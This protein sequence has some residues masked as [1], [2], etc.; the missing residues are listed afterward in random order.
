MLNEELSD[1]ETKL[2]NYKRGL[3]QVKARLVEFKEN[4][5]MFC[6]RIRVL[7]R[8]VEIS[9]NKIEYLKNELEQVKKEKESLDNKLTGFGNALKDLYNLLG[10]QRSDKNKEGLGY[11]L[12][13]FVDDTV[14][15]YRRPTPI[16]DASKCNKCELQSSNFSV[17]EHGESTCSIMSKPMIKFMKEVDCSRVI[18]INNTE[19]ARKSTVKYAEIAVLLKP[20][21][22]PIVV[23]R[24]NMNVSQPKMTSFAKTA[25][26]NVK[27]SFQRKSTVKNQ[28]RVPRASTV[29]KK[30]PTVDSKFPT[31]KSTLNADLRDKGKAVKAPARWIWRPKQNTSEQEY[32]TD[33][34]QIVDFLEA[35]HIRR[36]LKLNDEE[37]ISSLPDAELFENLSLMGYNIL[38]SQSVATTYTRRSRGI[39]IGSLWPMRIPIISAK[40][41]RK[42]KVTETEVPKKKKLQKQ[43]DAQVAREMEEEFDREDRRL[44]KQAARD[45]E[46]A[47]IHVEEELKLMIEGI[48]KNNE[49][50]A[51]HLSKYEEAEADLSVGDKIKLI[52][53]LVKYQDHR[54]EI[55]KYQA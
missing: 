15:D 20:G 12:P 4:E 5:V 18:K 43:I 47:R 36:H 52:S 24:P 9:D 14:T 40:D 49:V 35:S 27:R 1:C 39:T 34:H 46:I 7:K 11:G 48:D 44:S 29:T 8:D 32:N 10:S 33:F 16:I 30:F 50:I 41:K 22:T 37:G 25:H 45:S 55:L 3:S 2:Y 17:F 13:E 42:E 26:S 28:P 23:S 54:V 6:E 31:A 53:E 51:K 19:N 21:T 38:P